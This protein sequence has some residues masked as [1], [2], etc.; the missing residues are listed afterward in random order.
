MIF[1]KTCQKKNC[2]KVFPELSEHSIKL[3]N[4]IESVSV[5][6]KAALIGVNETAFLNSLSA[7]TGV[8]MV[9]T[10]LLQTKHISGLAA[11]H[12]VVAMSTTS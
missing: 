3:A 7:N 9:Q 11:K 2:G 12:D 4:L 6:Q 8:W 10:N 1:S 5:W